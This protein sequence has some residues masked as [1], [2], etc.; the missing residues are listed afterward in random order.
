MIFVVLFICVI[1]VILS[2]VIDK[3]KLFCLFTALSVVIFSITLAIVITA[4]YNAKVGY[5]TRNKKK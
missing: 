5:L 1:F 3:E 2:I 4:G